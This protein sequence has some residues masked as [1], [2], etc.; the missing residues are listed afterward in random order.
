MQHLGWCF[1]KY[2]GLEQA[3]DGETRPCR[4]GNCAPT[5]LTLREAQMDLG[6]PVLFKPH[7]F[8]GPLTWIGRSPIRPD[9]GVSVRGGGMRPCVHASAGAADRHAP[10]GARPRLDRHDDL[11][12]VGGRRH[13]LLPAGQPA[14]DLAA[15]RPGPLCRLPVAALAGAAQRAA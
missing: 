12:P 14:L 10:S 15:A 6:L 5:S 8:A 1:E 2:L 7:Y 9:A 4:S 3:W 13:L 11:A